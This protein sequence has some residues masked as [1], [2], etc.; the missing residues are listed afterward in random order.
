MTDALLDRT[1]EIG[2]EGHAG[3]HHTLDECI[4]EAVMQSGSHDVLR[5][6]TTS[7]VVSA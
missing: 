6:S 5:T 2:S 3:L 7:V 4:G 1:V